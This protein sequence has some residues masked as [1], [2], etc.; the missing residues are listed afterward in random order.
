V[1][2]GGFALVAWPAEYGASGV[3]TFIVSQDG[4][5][6][7]KD[8]GEDTETAVDGIQSFDPD[9]SWTAVVT[10]DEAPKDTPDA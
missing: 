10:T 7:Q 2:S 3:Q 9:S 4:V 5:V 8:L 1:L 6:F